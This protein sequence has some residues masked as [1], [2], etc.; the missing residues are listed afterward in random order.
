MSSTFNLEEVRK[1][2]SDPIIGKIAS[3]SKRIAKLESDNIEIE[4]DDLTG[5]GDS[6]HTKVWY[7]DNWNF[8]KR[9]AKKYDYVLLDGNNDW[10]D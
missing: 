9:H 10:V 8:A 2:F 1:K 7:N 3:F 6:D 4:K 5:Y